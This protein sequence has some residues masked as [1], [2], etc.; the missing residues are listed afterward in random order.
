MLRINSAS[1]RQ[2]LR[3]DNQVLIV[4]AEREMIAAAEERQG[5]LSLQY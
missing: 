4:I 3:I 5:A 1:Y 2:R